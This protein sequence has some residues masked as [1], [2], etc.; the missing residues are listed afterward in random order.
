MPRHLRQPLS[1]EFL[2]L[3]GDLFAPDA[4]HLPSDTDLAIMYQQFNERYF[5][6]TLPQATVSWS[7]RM[8]IAGCCYPNERD[9]RLS[10]H[11]HAHY[12][13]D[14]KGTLL[15]EMLHLIY[16]SHNADFKAAAERLGISIHCKDYP[17]VHPRSKYVYI[18]PGCGEVYRRSKRADMSCGKCSG[19]RYDPRYKLVLKQAQKP[20]QSR[21]RDR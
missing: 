15:H 8:R 3:Q 6:G 20:R 11:Y 12:P 7:T 2:R 13:D 9:I 4:T 14:L 19:D 18:C 5:A 21:R 16:P 17:G 1:E 10:T